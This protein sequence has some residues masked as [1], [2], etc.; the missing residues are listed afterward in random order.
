MSEDETNS[1]MRRRSDHW[2]G[3]KTLFVIIVASAALWV[4]IAL[5]L[6]IVR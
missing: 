3:K 5:I 4:L 2:S 1:T 6:H